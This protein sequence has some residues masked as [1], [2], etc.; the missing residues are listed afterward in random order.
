MRACVLGVGRV[1]QGQRSTL[2]KMV[3]RRPAG[4]SILSCSTTGCPR[5]RTYMP[6]FYL[7]AGAGDGHVNHS[8]KTVPLNKIPALVLDWY[9]YRSTVDSFRCHHSTKSSCLAP[10]TPACRCLSAHGTWAPPS[11]WRCARAAPPC[12][13]CPFSPPTTTRPPPV[14]LPYTYAAQRRAGRRRTSTAHSTS[15][16][17][18]YKCRACAQHS[19]CT[20]TACEACADIFAVPIAAP[21]RGAQKL[22]LLHFPS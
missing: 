5:A 8:S 21:G 17:C 6:P 20:L 12:R 15:G 4:P 18:A 13:S 14:R 10:C 1:L 2:R 19:G 9:T 16:R 3:L 22:P 7:D 11:S